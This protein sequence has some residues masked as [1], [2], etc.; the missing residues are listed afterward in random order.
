[1][2]EPRCGSAARR[3]AARPPHSPGAGRG[4]GLDGAD[5]EPVGRVLQGLQ[6]LLVGLVVILHG[7]EAGGPRRQRGS[8]GGGTWGWA[9]GAPRGL[10]AARLSRAV[11]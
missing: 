9:G 2:E 8:G 6:G 5:A 1:M 7:G 3:R 4:R 11:R 10:W